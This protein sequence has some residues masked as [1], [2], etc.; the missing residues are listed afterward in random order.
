MPQIEHVQFQSWHCHVT[1]AEYGNGRL[2]IVLTDSTT[3]QPIA[4]ASINVPDEVLASDEV[5]IKDFA[6]NRGMLS[7]LVAAGVVSQ[8]LRFVDSGY[9]SVPICKYIGINSK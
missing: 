2:A 9:V 3:H 6:E 8:P 1:Y 5:A 7:V 4:K